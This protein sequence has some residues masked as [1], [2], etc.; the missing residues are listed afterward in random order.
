MAVGRAYVPDQVIL[1]GLGS[2]MV[3]KNIFDVSPHY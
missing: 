1:D 3:K 2:C